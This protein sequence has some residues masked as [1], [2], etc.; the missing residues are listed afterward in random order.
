MRSHSFHCRI[1]N[2]S[3]QELQNTADA[4]SKKYLDDM[5][6]QMK[7]LVPVRR[8]RALKPRPVAN[9]SL[10]T[11]DSLVIDSPVEN[12]FRTVSQISHSKWTSKLKSVIKHYGG[13][14]NNSRPRLGE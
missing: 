1:F 13:L 14:N 7:P 10:T 3:L 9:R 11:P 2:R 8:P 4:I 6:S 5:K 12:I